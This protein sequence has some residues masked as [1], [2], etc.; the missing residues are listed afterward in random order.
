MLELKFNKY[1]FSDLIFGASYRYYS[2]TKAF[3]YQESYEGDEFLT[4]AYRSDDYKLKPFTSNNYGL[5]LT[6]LL[7]GLIKADAGLEFLRNSSL[8]FM[9]FRYVNDLEFSANIIQGS[10][11]FS[12]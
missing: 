3:F 7:R 10:I 6:Y 12:I 2:Q 9:F 11:K 8:E 5:T 4:D 1:I